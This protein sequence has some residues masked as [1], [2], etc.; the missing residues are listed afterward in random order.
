MEDGVDVKIYVSEIKAYSIYWLTWYEFWCLLQIDLVFIEEGFLG[1]ELGLSK[2]PEKQE[3]ALRGAGTMIRHDSGMLQQL[4]II[5]KACQQ[6]SN[7]AI[8]TGITQ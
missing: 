7:N 4:Y 5:D 8:L 3:C 2:L 1:S 6:L